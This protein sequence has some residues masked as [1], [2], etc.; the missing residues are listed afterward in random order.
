MAT[1][2]KQDDDLLIISEDDTSSNS[3]W[4]IEFSFDF[5]E[6]SSKKEEVSEVKIED[7]V[8][9]EES[10]VSPEEETANIDLWVSLDGWKEKVEASPME[11]S[12]ETADTSGE[13]EFSFDLGGAPENQTEE[14]VV[15]DIEPVWDESTSL[16]DN[17]SMNDILAGTVAQ[18]TAR[19]EAIATTKWGKA[20]QEEEIKAQ[21]KELQAQVKELESDM[22][23]LDNESD[24]I[25]ANIAQLE[26][27]KLN[28]VKEHNAKRATKK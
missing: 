1:A 19:K 8:V 6:D 2:T 12:T 26:E 9:S 13:E 22:S 23:M 18:L 15:A 11:K 21:I 24:K 20:Q 28:P 27:M 16:W 4:D 3:K 10:S 7:L 14:V 5:W 25:T 17:S